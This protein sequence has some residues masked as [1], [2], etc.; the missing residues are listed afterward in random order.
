MKYSDN[1][2]IT[3]QNF[4]IRQIAFAPYVPN[5]T[6]VT[7]LNTLPQV[8]PN[9]SKDF[10]YVKN[11]N[12]ESGDLAIYDLHGVLLMTKSIMSFSDAIDISSLKQGLYLLKVDGQIIKFSKL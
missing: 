8:Y 7:T 11:C 5:A 6:D 4:L 10:I 2:V 12:K 3:Y 1:S 9:P